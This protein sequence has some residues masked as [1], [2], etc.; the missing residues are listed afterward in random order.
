M[1]TIQMTKEWQP[2]PTK[3][4][5]ESNPVIE[6]KKLSAADMESIKNSHFSAE[7]LIGLSWVLFDDFEDT[8]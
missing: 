4:L 7:D 5:V 3:N 8:S 1:S 6:G 2:E